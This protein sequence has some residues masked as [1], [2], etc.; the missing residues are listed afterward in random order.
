MDPIMVK[1][2][3]QKVKAQICSPMISGIFTAHAHEFITRDEMF[4][5]LLH[6]EVQV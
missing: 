1:K 2:L 3:N 5:L 4:D 6:T